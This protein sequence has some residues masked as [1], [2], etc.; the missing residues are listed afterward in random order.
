MKITIVPNC[1]KPK[2]FRPDA[3]RLRSYYTDKNCPHCGYWMRVPYTDGTSEC[4]S[5]DHI[6]MRS[7][8]PKTNDPEITRLGRAY[9]P[10]CS[11]HGDE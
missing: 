11:A 3:K 7:R 10:R 1:R 4:G 8:F 6:G 9:T 5:C 2:A